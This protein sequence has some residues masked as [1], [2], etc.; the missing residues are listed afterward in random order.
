MHKPNEQYLAT[1]PK[2]LT[3]LETNTILKNNNKI[4]FITIQMSSV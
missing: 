3:G 1:I 2:V 4:A